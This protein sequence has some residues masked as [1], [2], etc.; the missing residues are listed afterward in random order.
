MFENL[1]T[2]TKGQ[3]SA[4]SVMSK[5]SWMTFTEIDDAII[6]KYGS[7][8]GFWF[9][10]LASM[11]KKGVIERLPKQSKNEVDLWRLK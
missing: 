1:I 9:N 3:Y 8:N 10:T 7:H 6:Q 11:E 2:L 5:D 4:Y